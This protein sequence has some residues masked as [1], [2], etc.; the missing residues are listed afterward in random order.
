MWSLFWSIRLLPLVELCWYQQ[1]D[2]QT[3]QRGV[4]EENNSPLT[5]T[6]FWSNCQ[7]NNRGRLSSYHMSDVWRREGAMKDLVIRVFSSFQSW[8][9]VLNSTQ[10]LLRLI[11]N[12][13]RLSHYVPKGVCDV[14]PA[15]GRVRVNGGGVDAALWAKG[16]L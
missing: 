9:Q 6:C 3:G 5:L 1:T 14:E 12:K 16:R 15:E 8:G 4:K 11:N 2:R 7:E 13:N 10:S